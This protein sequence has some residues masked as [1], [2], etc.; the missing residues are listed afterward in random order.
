[1]TEQAPGAPTGRIVAL[2]S[3]A[4]PRGAMGRAVLDAVRRRQPGGT[5]ELCEVEDALSLLAALRLD[6][7][8]VV[9]DALIGGAEGEVRELDP[10]GIG[11]AGFTAASPRG[12]SIAGAVALAR[13]LA[14]ADTSPAIK[15]V[16]VATGSRRA[17]ALTP[18]LAVA[19]ERAAELALA[20]VQAGT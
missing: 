14:P 4:S 6:G 8:V 9:V 3:P 19:V 5:I 11:A 7:P 15:V 17:F 13:F 18:L 20:L 16:G 1:M 2:S 12:L 10:T